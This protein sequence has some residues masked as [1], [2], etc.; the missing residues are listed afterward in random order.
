MS[1]TSFT[2]LNANTSRL[3]SSYDAASFSS[4]TSSYSVSNSMVFLRSMHSRNVALASRNER[5]NRR[6]AAS[7]RFLNFTLL[8]SFSSLLLYS[9]SS[10]SSSED[11]TS[12]EEEEEPNPLASRAALLSAYAAAISL[13]SMD[14]CA[15]SHKNFTAIDA[16]SAVCARFSNRAIIFASL[17][18]RSKSSATSRSRFNSFV[19]TVSINS[20]SRLPLSSRIS[21]ISASRDVSLVFIVSIN[22]SN[23]FLATPACSLNLSFSSFDLLA[24]R[25]AFSNSLSISRIFFLISDSSSLFSPS[26]DRT[27]SISMLC[28]ICIVS[29]S[30]IFS[31][32]IRRIFSLHASSIFSSFSFARFT[33]STHRLSTTSISFSFFLSKSLTVRFNRSISSRIPL[34]FV[35][36][37]RSSISL[38]RFAS[39]IA[40]FVREITSRFALSSSNTFDAYAILSFSRD[41]LDSSKVFRNKWNASSVVSF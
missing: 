12:E 31:S 35:L 36:F 39:S 15:S 7:A 41:D 27:C 23:F 32:L 29:K 6:L 10:S 30:L 1:A 21:S 38:V 19:F 37:S 20:S 18:L 4:L 8:F 28:F 9:L 13:S 5:S 11:D 33:A 24:S 40:S 34:S 3:F 25:L 17:S 22:S 16:V 26:F 14:F 2:T